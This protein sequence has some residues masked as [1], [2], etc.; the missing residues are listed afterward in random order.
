MREIVHV[1]TGQCGNQVGAK[2]N[3]Y[4]AHAFLYCMTYDVP[5][6]STPHGKNKD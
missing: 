5:P 6:F 2:V 3:K 1:Q 4:H